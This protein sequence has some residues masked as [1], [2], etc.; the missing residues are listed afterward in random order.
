MSCKRDGVDGGVQRW[1]VMGVITVKEWGMENF[2]WGGLEGKLML[3]VQDNDVSI[4]NTML[5]FRLLFL[6][7]IFLEK[8]IFLWWACAGAR[9]I[10]LLVLARWRK[11]I[12]EKEKWDAKLPGRTVNS[13]DW[14]SKDLALYSVLALRLPRE[15]L[16][17]CCTTELQTMC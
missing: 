11:F 10:G 8:S 9:R 17:C 1:G 2:Y 15:D 14:Q 16:L 7:G 12:H 5:C 13:S 4:K 6:W 3:A